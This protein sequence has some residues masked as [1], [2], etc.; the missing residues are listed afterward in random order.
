M[1]NHQIRD[2]VDT[3]NTA[4]DSI[5]EPEYTDPGST[6]WINFANI[7]LSPAFVQAWFKLFASQVYKLEAGLVLVKAH[8]ENAFVPIA[9]WPDSSTDVTCLTEAAQKALSERQGV[10]ILPPENLGATNNQLT[11]I[12]LPIEF[13]TKLYGVVVLGVSSREKREL[14]D[15][16]RRLYW[17]SAWLINIF[18]Q[19]DL[20][21]AESK[22]ERAALALD[23]GLLVLEK[24]DL[25]E[26]LFALV[27]TLAVKLGLRR[28]SVGLASKGHDI[29]V[30]AVSHAAHFKR[31]SE[32]MQLIE[33]AMEE[34]FD[35]RKNLVYPPFSNSTMDS[36]GFEITVDHQKLVEQETEGAVATFL[37]VDHGQPFGVLMCEYTAAKNLTR[38]DL[39][40]GSSVARLLAPILKQQ[41]ELDLWLTGKWKRRLKTGMEKLLGPYHVTYKAI[42]LGV[43]LLLAFLLIAEGEFRVTAKTAIEGLVQRA[44]VAPF[45]GYIDQAPVRAGDTVT[46]G[47]II[48]TLDER[49][50]KLE[51]GRIESEREQTLRKYRDALS[52]HDRASV[53]VLGAQL[54]QSEAEMG[55]VRE[56][57]EHSK[58]RAPFDGIVVSGDLSQMLGAPVEQGK[59]LFEIAPLDAYRVVLKVDERDIAYVKVG[60][61]GQLA[62]SGITADPLPFTVK[63]ITPISTSEEGLTYFR[64][65]A[66]LDQTSPFLRPG[67]EGVG[68]IQVGEDKLWWIWSRRLVDWLKITFWTWT[69]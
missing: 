49:D 11:Q 38:E 15:I 39:D 25:N 21:R 63:K 66:E 33:K 51:K 4:T 32:F 5:G 69:P 29:K 31:Q 59:V 30:K 1:M 2:R 40:I 9:T 8:E 34:A 68:K 57:L 62:L 56:K 19:D 53:S 10:V 44:A 26:G 41:Q 13:E 47:Q 24:P 7:G 36:G 14:T 27:N 17:G 58:I 43:V 46:A 52:K 23:I 50:L 6:A 12:A 61:S 42:A 55:L 16:R 28:V 20:H 35:Q 18:L 64:V 48:A 37:L 22:V 60:H 45:E 65:E 3:E 67:M 54:N